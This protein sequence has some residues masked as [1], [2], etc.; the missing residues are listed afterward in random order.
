MDRNT[1]KS[2]QGMIFDNAKR[3]ADGVE[4]ERMQGILADSIKQM[5]K[6]KTEGGETSASI[7][8]QIAEKNMMMPLIRQ[9]GD[10]DFETKKAV[11]ELFRLCLKAPVQGGMTFDYV[12]EHFDEVLSR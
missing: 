10:I 11:A 8:V 1:Y 9:M 2:W 12:L 4:A 3:G 7:S 6:A 5:L